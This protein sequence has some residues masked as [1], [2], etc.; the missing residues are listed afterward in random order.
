VLAERE[1]PVLL[2]GETG[3][4]KEVFARAIHTGGPLKHGPIEK[5]ELDHVLRTVRPSGREGGATV[6][7]GRG[8]APSEVGPRPG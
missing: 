7:S 6:G 8:S 4:G 2:Q 1:V 3:V 5:Y